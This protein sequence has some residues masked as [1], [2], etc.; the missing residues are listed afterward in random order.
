MQMVRWLVQV[1]K[2][3][4]DQADKSGVT[5]LHIAAYMGHYETVWWLV[6]VGKA[7]VDHVSEK[8]STPL[9]M[10]AQNCHIGI[11]AWLIKEGKVSVDQVDKSGV[12]PLH[13]AA[14]MGRDKMVRWLI[15]EG[16]ASVDQANDVGQT[17]LFAAVQRCSQSVLRQANSEATPLSS[18]GYKCDMDMLRWLVEEGNANVNTVSVKGATL[19]LFALGAEVVKMDV[20]HFLLSMGARVG[21][22]NHPVFISYVKASIQKEVQNLEV[23]ISMLFLYH[24]LS[25]YH[26][27]LILHVPLFVYEGGSH[28]ACDA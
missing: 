21:D 10:A 24:F 6:G 22:L 7:S 28:R 3:S 16:N 5:P 15:G 4:V 9:F 8:G 20:V 1:G 2:A 12:T 27:L 13:I 25:P 26:P 14:Y 23:L 19:L 17:P 11:V 18:A